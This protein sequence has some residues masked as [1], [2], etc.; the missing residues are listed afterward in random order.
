ML[1]G[2]NKALIG[3]PPLSQDPA[4]RNS[5]TKQPILG[6]TPANLSPEISNKEPIY[7]RQHQRGDVVDGSQLKISGVS[8]IVG[9]IPGVS[10]RASSA[11]RE[12]PQLQQALRENEELQQQ[13]QQLQLQLQQKGGVGMGEKQRPATARRLSVDGEH[14]VCVYVFVYTHKH[15]CMY[16]CSERRGCL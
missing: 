8:G 1:Y 5:P 10:R 3:L 11:G 2:K 7:T 13:L 9:S 16:I 14:V 4:L 12:N 15:V 6:R